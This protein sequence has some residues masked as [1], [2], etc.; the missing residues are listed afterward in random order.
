M[1]GRV[2]SSRVDE[3]KGDPGNPLTEAEVEEKFR[4]LARAGGLLGERDVEAIIARVRTL[5]RASSLRDLL[6]GTAA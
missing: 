2:Y 1:D 4:M 3:P 5:E 6:P